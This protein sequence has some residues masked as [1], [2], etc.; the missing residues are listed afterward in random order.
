MV[1]SLRMKNGRVL[2]P[3]QPQNNA[4]TYHD[5]TSCC[6]IAV[7]CSCNVK[8]TGKQTNSTQEPSSETSIRMPLTEADTG[9]P[10]VEQLTFMGRERPKSHT[11]TRCLSSSLLPSS[12]G[13]MWNRQLRKPTYTAAP[14][15]EHRDARGGNRRIA[16]PMNWLLRADIRRDERNLQCNGEET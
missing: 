4:K 11:T 12:S 13:L 2:R 5:T 10:S 14:K 6:N 7:I 1:V 9:P 15:R 8:E 16:K 3:L